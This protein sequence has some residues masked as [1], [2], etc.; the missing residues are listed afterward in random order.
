MRRIL[1]ILVWIAY[2]LAAAATALLAESRQPPPARDSRAA[3]AAIVTKITKADYEDDRPALQR[4]FEELAPFLEE[5]ALVSRIRYWRG[6]ALWRRVLNGFNDKAP[7]EEQE[8]DMKGCAAEFDQ[9]VAS[10]PSFVDARLGKGSCLFALSRLAPEDTESRDKAMKLFAELREESKT[11]A[12]DNPRVLL[13]V[14]ASLW[15]MPVEKGGGQA[16]AMETYE[17]GLRAARRKAKEKR[18]PLEPSWGEPELLANLA[19]AHMHRDTPDLEAAESNARAALE[20]VPTWHY[21][22]DILMPQ[23]QE[24][25]AKKTAG[26]PSPSPAAR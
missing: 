8:K 14:A 16:K 1:R 15:F 10:D 18:D 26:T 17:Q 25:K 4:H 19:W 5:K 24:A 9:S 6:F 2:L 3:A 12:A 22:R 21:A 13:I 20:I 7:R 23:I 11:T